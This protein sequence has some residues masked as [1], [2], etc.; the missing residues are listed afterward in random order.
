[1]CMNGFSGPFCDMSS[2]CAPNPCYNGGQCV[3]FG[4]SFRCTCPPPFSGLTCQNQDLCNPNPCVNGGKCINQGDSFSCSCRP[5]YS[6][7]RCE[8]RDRNLDDFEFYFSI[9]LFSQI[10]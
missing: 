8:I 4:N 3:S 7:M 2:T 10:L 1:M 6:G 5:G 9:Y